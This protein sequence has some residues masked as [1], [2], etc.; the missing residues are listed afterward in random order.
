[1]FAGIGILFLGGKTI[2]LEIVECQFYGRPTAIASRVLLASNGRWSLM[3]SKLI[4]FL[5]LIFS[6]VNV[7]TGRRITWNGY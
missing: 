4:I 3:E 1:M 2:T 6:R 7:F 5:I